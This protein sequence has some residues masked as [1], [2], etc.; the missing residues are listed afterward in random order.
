MLKIL[1][2][3]VDAVRTASDA[4]AKENDEPQKKKAK[5]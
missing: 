1:T 5:C 2:H 4:D 3:V